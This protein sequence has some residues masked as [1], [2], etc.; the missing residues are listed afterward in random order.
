MSLLLKNQGLYG[1]SDLQF[2]KMLKRLRPLIKGF[3]PVSLTKLGNAV[4]DQ[5]ENFYP[6]IKSYDIY[7]GGAPKYAFLYNED[8]N[9]LLKL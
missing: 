1:Y 8:T 7:L 3:S 5:K 2:I 9:K 6:I 4:L